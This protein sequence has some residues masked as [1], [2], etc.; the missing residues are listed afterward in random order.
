MLIEVLCTRTN[1]QIKAI[2]EEYKKSEYMYRGSTR[3]ALLHVLEPSSCDTAGVTAE[4]L[5]K[6]WRF[7]RICCSKNFVG[8]AS[9]FLT[10]VKTLIEHDAQWWSKFCHQ[11]AI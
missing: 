9:R 2:K 7:Q 8:G 10:C 3:H 4:T 1:T 11:K 5:Q 6:Y